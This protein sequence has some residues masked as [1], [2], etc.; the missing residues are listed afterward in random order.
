MKLYLTY[1]KY[2]AFGFVFVLSPRT[3][4]AQP[5]AGNLWFA[6]AFSYAQRFYQNYN[7]AYGSFD[8]DCAQITTI[9]LDN[10]IT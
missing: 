3:L 9:K 6:R 10:I 7:P 4:L 2:L 8:S 5:P 1:L